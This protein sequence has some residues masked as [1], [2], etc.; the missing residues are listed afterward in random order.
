MSLTITRIYL[1]LHNI[2]YLLILVVLLHTEHRIPLYKQNC[3]GPA[4]MIWISFVRITSL[5]YLNP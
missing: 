1:C 5:R 2:I 3:Q 4:Y